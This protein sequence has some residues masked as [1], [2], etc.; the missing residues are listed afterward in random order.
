MVRRTRE[1]SWLAYP[2]FQAARCSGSVLKRDG[3]HKRDGGQVNH[4]V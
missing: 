3:V 2:D 4:H 1:D